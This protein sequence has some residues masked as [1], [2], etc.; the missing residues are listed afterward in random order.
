M[1]RPLRIKFP[2][3]FYHVM[4]SGNTGMKIYRSERDREKFLFKQGF[5]KQGNSPTENPETPP[6]A[7][8]L[9][10]AVS[11]EFDCG[12]KNILRK[13][14]KSNLAR[15]V[16]IYLCWQLTGAT[17][18]ALGRRFDICGAGI[19]ARH[20]R[21]A[22]KLRTDRKLKGRDDRIRRKIQNI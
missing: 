7:D 12:I 19:A 18:V 8:E 1:A 21:I 6:N 9:I 4:N 16:A 20:A 17:S 14:K 5:E 2:G 10:Q 13:G 11:D 22:K 15:H 3:A